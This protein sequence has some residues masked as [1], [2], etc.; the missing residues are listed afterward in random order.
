[1][2][3]QSCAL[4]MTA[5]SLLSWTHHSLLAHP[6]LILLW[7]DPRQTCSCA[8]AAKLPSV[9]QVHQG[10]TARACPEALSG[11]SGGVGQLQEGEVSVLGLLAA[12]VRGAF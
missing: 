9:Q 8:P 6:A 1:M 4:G 3:T 10:T 5:A 2:M 11:N 12:A 7:K